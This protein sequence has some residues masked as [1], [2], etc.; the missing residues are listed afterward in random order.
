[1]DDWYEIKT[2]TIR[3]NGGSGILAFYKNCLS[4]ALKQ[5]YPEVEWNLHRFNRVPVNW[6]NEDRNQR[7]FFDN[8]AKKLG[9]KQ[10]EDWY[11]VKNLAGLMYEHKGEH[12]MNKK[13]GGS[14]SSAIMTTYP[15]YNWKS[16]KFSST[17]KNYWKKRENIVEFMEHVAKELNIRKLDDWYGVSRAQL[18]QFR[19]MRRLMTIHGGGLLKVLAFLHPNFPWDFSRNNFTSTRGGK[20]QG[21]VSN[22]IQELFPHSTDL[23]FNFSHPEWR[24]SDTQLAMSFDIWIPSLKLAFEYN[25]QQHY[26]ELEVYHDAGR[27]KRDQK[28]VKFVKRMEFH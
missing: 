11:E 10:W 4:T 16:W 15:E 9:I 26:D 20:T 17:P 7:L 5:V 1:M 2:E 3:E 25:G 23:H 24:F 21:L 6:W 8:L 18:I 19:P 28:N 22:F 27:M 14:P 13:Y 12:L